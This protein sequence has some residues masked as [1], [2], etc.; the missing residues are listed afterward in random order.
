MTEAEAQIA[1]VA[2][3]IES[4]E[5]NINE[6]QK[7]LRLPYEQWDPVYQ[8]MYATKNRVLLMEEK[9]R[10][11]DEKRLL[12]EKEKLLLEEKIQGKGSADYGKLLNRIDELPTRLRE[13]MKDDQEKSARISG[14]STKFGDSLKDALNV[15]SVPLDLHVIS[16]SLQVS[17][18]P[19]YNWLSSKEDSPENRIR[20]LRYLEQVLQL[21]NQQKFIVWDTN[22]Y[23]NLLDC[24]IADRTIRG[25]SDVIISSKRSEEFILEC[26]HIVFELKKPENQDRKQR[27]TEIE[28][29]AVQ[30]RSNYSVVGVLSDLNDFW[31]IYWFE[32][33]NDTF[34]IMSAVLSRQSA[35]GFL[36]YHLGVLERM[37]DN[38]RFQAAYEDDPDFD[39]DPDEDLDQRKDRIDKKSRPTYRS[40]KASTLNSAFRKSSYGPEDSDDIYRYIIMRHMKEIPGLQWPKYMTMEV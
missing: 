29:I 33:E 7:L 12:M 8:E 11:M 16:T 31:E 15:Q 13:V 2:A 10:L 21:N 17:R 38:G 37:K 26:A 27:Q 35:I 25:T 28:L 18:V 24:S 34:K 23:A 30:R 14:I 5:N 39:Q 1:D 3:K 22:R 6:L 32:A 9:G 19:S 4:V 36:R 20:Y 40:T